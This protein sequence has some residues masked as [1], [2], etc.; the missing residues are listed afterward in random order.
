MPHQYRISVEKLNDTQQTEQSLSFETINHDDIFKI[1]EK[2]EGKFGFSEEQRN[3]FFVGLKLFSE[4]M[5]Q[6]HKNPLFDEF[7]PQFK[8]FMKKLKTSA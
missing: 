1:L 3:N 4:V 5:L 7:G 2:V 8:Q 6:E